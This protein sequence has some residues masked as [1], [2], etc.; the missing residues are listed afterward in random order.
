MKNLANK[1]K[2][3][4]GKN[5]LQLI[6]VFLVLAVVGVPTYAHQ[7]QQSNKEKYAKE[8]QAK[9]EQLQKEKELAAKSADKPTPAPEPK[10]EEPA[11]ELKKTYTA[12]TEKKTYT[13]R[14]V[15]FTELVE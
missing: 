1:V 7:V 8:Q 9:L 14:L 4:A 6:S 15:V 3:F 11:P 13:E 5:K 10:K 2:S 12:T